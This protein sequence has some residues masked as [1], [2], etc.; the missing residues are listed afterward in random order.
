LVEAAKYRTVLDSHQLHGDLLAI[1]KSTKDLSLD[2]HAI[3]KHSQ[4]STIV[5]NSSKVITEEIVD[6]LINACI[7]LYFSRNI[8]LEKP[9]Q[10]LY[11]KLVE[12]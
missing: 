11:I 8:Q 4:F 12:T 5:E 9:S 6:S 7:L 1:P 10:D 2:T 3:L